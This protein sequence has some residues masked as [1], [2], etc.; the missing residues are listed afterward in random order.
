[1]CRVSCKYFETQ[2][3][4]IYSHRERHGVCSKRE[5]GC[6]GHLAVIGRH[7]AQEGTPGCDWT[8]PCAGGNCSG[9]YPTGL[10]SNLQRLGSTP[11]QDSAH[12]C[13]QPMACSPHEPQGNYT[14][15]HRASQEER[16]EVGVALPH[17]IHK[18]VQGKQIYSENI[19]Y[20]ETVQSAKC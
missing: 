2:C 3:Q 8:A 7:P 1:M 6:G 19:R 10:C 9:S 20:G 11:K 14:C 5:L 13:D 18:L 12:S 4:Q 16:A 15:P 17:L